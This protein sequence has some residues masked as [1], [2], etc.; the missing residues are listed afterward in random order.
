MKVLLV[1]DEPLALRSMDEIIKRAFEDNRHYYTFINRSKEAL[2]LARQQK[3]DAIFLDLEM[4]GNR[5]DGTRRQ[6]ICDASF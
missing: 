4:P 1:D 3:F 5:G 6:I 2:N